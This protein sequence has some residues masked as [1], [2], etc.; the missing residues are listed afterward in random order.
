M[1]M[2]VLSM[3]GSY[4]MPYMKKKVYLDTTI[5]SYYYDDREKTDFLIKATK[6]WF[7]NEAKLYEISI[8]DETL[9]EAQEGDHPH[10]EKIMDFLA[11][12]QIL[13]FD[14]IL[15]EIVQ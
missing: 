7:M 14:E 15:E 10:K 13:P 8:S 4:I 3:I 12:W 6:S 9:V 1:F 5:P 11:R 2:F